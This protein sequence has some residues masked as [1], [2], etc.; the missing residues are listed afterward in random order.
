MS[1]LPTVLNFQLI[2]LFRRDCE[3]VGLRE[4]Q[5]FSTSRRV[6]NCKLD[7]VQR[8]LD[9]GVFVE[10]LFNGH[11]ASVST[12]DL[13]HEG[14]TAAFKKA[15]QT[16]R[17]AATFKVFNFTEK[18]RPPTTGRYGASSHFGFSSEAEKQ[19]I[20]EMILL[21]EKM[22]V[23]EKI[24]NTLCHLVSIET[25]VRYL[26]SSPS[27]W[28]QNFN[29]VMS[30]LSATAENSFE[31]QTRSDHGGLARCYQKPMVSV[32]LSHFYETSS[33]IGEEACLLLEAANCPTQKCDLLLAPD[34][35]ILQIH[36][37]IGHPLEMD[38]I[39]GDERNFAGWS[40]VK[41]SD[42]GKLQYGS[43]LM[44]VVFDPTESEELA[45]YSF[46]DIGNSATKEFLIKEGRL[47]KGLG[48]LESQARLGQAGVANARSSSWTRPAI[49]RMA[50]INL[51]PGTESLES[52]IQRTENGVLMR[53]NRS[54]SID[55]ERNKFQF[56]CEWGEIIRDGELK[57]LVKNPNYQ[58]Q[59]L[60][61][62]R[63]LKGLSAHSE[64][65]G[66]P[67]CGKGEPSQLIR[68]G[69]RS[70]YALFSDIEVFG[71]G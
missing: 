48:S 6:R 15:L 53:S 25:Q 10:V 50:N 4:V 62:W 24:K 22:R 46:D 69:H 30:D 3:W 63:N 68:V 21:G 12:R 2:D 29:I 8:H 49:D 13:S 16:A 5:E 65:Y 31:S 39:L 42:F 51:V 38:R 36:E 14:L 56:G 27:D 1:F 66:S 58:G 60:S 59:T 35:M 47:L 19:L 45:S 18:V 28:Q 67:F 57:G 32:D 64:I 34:Q 52:L 41:P 55:D 43:P 17:L 40:F 71:G 20:H 33:K 11:L 26:S 23:S 9:R 37:S 54:W 61:F 7:S 70:P 44:N